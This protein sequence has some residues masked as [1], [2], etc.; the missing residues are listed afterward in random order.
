MVTSGTVVRPLDCVDRDPPAAWRWR[1]RFVQFGEDAPE[2]KTKASRGFVCFSFPPRAHFCTRLLIYKVCSVDGHQSH[3]IMNPEG[4][5]LNLTQ[6]LIVSADSSIPPV[7]RAQPSRFYLSGSALLG[8]GADS[9]GDDTGL[10]SAKALLRR[11]A[12]TS[13]ILQYQIPHFTPIPLTLSA[14]HRVSR[15]EFGLYHGLSSL[16]SGVPF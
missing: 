15:T 6:R 5:D 13:A 2:F 3:L 16:T 1:S 4:D 9:E 7:S 11:Q 12:F 14:P 10:E 8:D